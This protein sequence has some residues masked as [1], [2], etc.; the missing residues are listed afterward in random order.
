MIY[1][2]LDFWSRNSKGLGAIYNYKLFVL[3]FHMLTVLISCG[4]LENTKDFSIH[5]SP[6]A[7]LYWRLHHSPFFLD[8]GSLFFLYLHSL[9][10]LPIFVPLPL[11]FLPSP[12]ISACFSHCLPSLPCFLPSFIHPSFLQVFFEILPEHMCGSFLSA[13]MKFLGEMLCWW[14]WAEC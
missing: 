5:L 14:F 11:L 8:C 3:L 12:F 2:G 7:S 13:V 1:V 9:W 10:K 6:L 4:R